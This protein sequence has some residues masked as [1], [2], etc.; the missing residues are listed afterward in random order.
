MDGAVTP[1]N[2]ASRRAVHGGGREG[3]MKSGITGCC[4]TSVRRQERD[5]E[6]AN[7]SRDE[8]SAS[9]PGLS[10]NVHTLT[11]CRDVGLLMDMA[12][13]VKQRV[14]SYAWL[15]TY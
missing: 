13:Y 8:F 2:E 1:D 10:S 9:E 12:E 14:P 11:F 6:A 5:N 15:S 7:L 4:E 3:M